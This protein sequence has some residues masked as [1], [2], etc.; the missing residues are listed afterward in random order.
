HCAKLAAAYRSSGA[1]PKKTFDGRE[2]H[3]VARSPTSGVPVNC[4]SSVSK[5]RCAGWA[6][7]WPAMIS[8]SVS[9]ASAA[10]VALSSGDVHA[11][12]AY[13]QQAGWSEPNYLMEQMEVA[14]C[15][16][17]QATP[18]RNPTRMASDHQRDSLWLA[19]LLRLGR[20]AVHELLGL[21]QE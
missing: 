2:V 7:P 18:W 20:F 3:L 1:R 12:T 16:Q 10:C 17:A 19:S 8:P 15:G 14:V 9:A 13:H 4:C 21:A 11:N 5:R 6:S